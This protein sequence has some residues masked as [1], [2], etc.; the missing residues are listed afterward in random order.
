VSAENPITGGPDAARRVMERWAGEVTPAH[1]TQIQDVAA[2]NATYLQ[3]AE[4]EAGDTPR[5]R[6]GAQLLAE[7][8]GIVQDTVRRAHN[9]KGGE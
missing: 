8:L 3:Y 6:R 1:L 9:R 4:A 5:L 7:G 2:A